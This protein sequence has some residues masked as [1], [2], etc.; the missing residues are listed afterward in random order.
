MSILL[1][2][3]YI[4][5]VYMYSLISVFDNWI[6]RGGRSISNTIGA[7]GVVAPTNLCSGVYNN[8]SN[9]YML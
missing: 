1:D 9:A 4:I 5:Y 8:K 2:V 6:S 7:M 3:L